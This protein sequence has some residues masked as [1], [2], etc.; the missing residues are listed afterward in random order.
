MDQ[1]KKELSDMLTLFLTVKSILDTEKRLEI[2]TKNENFVFIFNSKGGKIE[3][4]L[5]KKTLKKIGFLYGI[6]KFSKPNMIED[7]KKIYEL[8]SFKKIDKEYLE[9]VFNMIKNDNFTYSLDSEYKKQMFITNSKGSNK[10]KFN[11]EILF[12]DDLFDYKHKY[13]NTNNYKIIYAV[14]LLNIIIL[15]HY[16]SLDEILMDR[17]MKKISYN[18][19]SLNYPYNELIIRNILTRN[20]IME[21]YKKGI[22]NLYYNPLFFS[23]LFEENSVGEHL[24]TKCKILMINHRNTMNDFTIE[25]SQLESTVNI[26][27]IEITYRSSYFSDSVYQVS[28]QCR[29][30]DQYYT[31]ERYFQDFN[32]VI[33]ENIKNDIEKIQL[34]LYDGVN[35]YTSTIDNVDLNKIQISCID[36]YNRLYSFIASLQFDLSNNIDTDNDKK[37]DYIMKKI[38]FYL[39]E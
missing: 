5:D 3:I 22:I 1:E 37:D 39:K 8:S 24:H 23:S 4:K 25:K 21:K 17:L 19:Y 35:I 28:I 32:E 36:H 31:I 18:I 2:I 7:E 12:C 16:L 33:I 13:A 27:H 20:N 14:K 10:L 30:I 38:I 6:T 34:N 15:L 9:I 26:N 29:L 11:P